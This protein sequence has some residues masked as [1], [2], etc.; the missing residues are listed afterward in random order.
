MS[1][2]LITALAAIL[3]SLVDVLGANETKRIN[4]QRRVR[5]DHRA[6]SVSSAGAQG[7]HVLYALDE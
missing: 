1:S 3:G 2:G 7:E 5:W 4:H 6:I